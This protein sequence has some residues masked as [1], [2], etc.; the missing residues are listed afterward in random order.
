MGADADDL[1]ADS[2]DRRRAYYRSVAILT[3]AGHGDPETIFWNYTFEDYV[4]FLDAEMFRRHT[5]E[6]FLWGMHRRIVISSGRV[7]E[8]SLPEYPDYE[9]PE[10][11]QLPDDWEE[12]A[13][14][15]PFVVTVEAPS[16]GPSSGDIQ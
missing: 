9:G 11:G 2:R 12:R 8:S 3:S 14:A 7:E 13:A 10:E 4:G 1:P 6:A 15:H 16:K 5:D